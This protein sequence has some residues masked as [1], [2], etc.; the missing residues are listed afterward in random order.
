M[1]AKEALMIAVLIKILNY[2]FMDD[3]IAR[4]IEFDPMKMKNALKSQLIALN[5]AEA[6]VVV[7]WNL[8]I[9]HQI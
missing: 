6:F 9:L 7:A 2:R 1:H 8:I 4:L 5:L 3:V